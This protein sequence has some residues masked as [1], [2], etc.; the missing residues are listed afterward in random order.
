MVAGAAGE[1]SRDASQPLGCTQTPLS[2]APLS[3]PVSQMVFTWS[4]AVP[5]VMGG[6]SVSL[7]VIAAQR[8][9]LGLLP[10]RGR[11]LYW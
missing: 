10:G 9:A 8:A 2:R 7:S 1:A 4:Q 3:R 11:A 5:R 6:H